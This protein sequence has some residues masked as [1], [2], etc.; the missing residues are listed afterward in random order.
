MQSSV[1]KIPIKSGYQAQREAVLNCPEPAQGR[2][3]GKI[4][5]RDRDQQCVREAAQAA[6][7]NYY[8]LLLS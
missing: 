5:R 8:S 6:Y 4:H 3:Y 2:W 1:E 7:L